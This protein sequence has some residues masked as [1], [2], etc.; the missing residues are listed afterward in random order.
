MPEIKVIFDAAEDFGF[1]VHVVGNAGAVFG[2]AGFGIVGAEDDRTHAGVAERG[3]AHGTG[4]QGDGEGAVLE[5]AAGL[6][7]LL[8]GEHF[9]VMEGVLAGFH[10]VVGTG[11][12]LA[13]AV[14]EDRADGDLSL[15]YGKLS[16]CQCQ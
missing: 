1:E 12:D 3:H 15:P 14:D 4:F 2:A 10:L 8:E 7:G 5:V 16:L 9:G 6:H 11:D 13:A